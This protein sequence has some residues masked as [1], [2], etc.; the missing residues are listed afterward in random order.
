[1]NVK[2]KQNVKDISPYQIL[3]R[4]DPAQLQ[5]SEIRHIQVGMTVASFKGISAKIKTIP[6]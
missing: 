2:G 6:K 3:T 5:I 1:M 4:P